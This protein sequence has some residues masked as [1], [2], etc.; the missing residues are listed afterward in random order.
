MQKILLV[1]D[2]S[3]A[4]NGLKILLQEDLGNFVFEEAAC[5]DSAME[6]I[7]LTDY[8][9]VILDMNMPGTECHK[10]LQTVFLSKPR[11]K[12]L[13]FSMN[14]EQIYAKKLLQIGVKGYV[15]KYEPV[16][17]IKNAVVSVLNDQRYISRNMSE[18]IA[19]DLASNKSINPFNELSPRQLEI[20]QHL[21][22][23]KSI[24]DICRILQL[25]SSTVSTQKNRIFEKLRISN[26]IDLY[27]YARIHMG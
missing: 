26:M 11:L 14:D 7:S 24:S 8:A 13:I 1:D 10:L 17:E 20:V 25:H 6:K 16:H 22:N 3:I 23:G 19:D 5:G 18:H 21:I 27:S 9:L 4:R 12:V 2:H 15:G